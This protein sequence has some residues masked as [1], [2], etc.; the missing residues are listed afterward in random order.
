V[1]WLQSEIPGEVRVPPWLLAEVHQ[2]RR[3][4]F[5]ELV[6]AGRSIAQIARTLNLSQRRVKEMK[7][8]LAAVRS[9]A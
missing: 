1:L 6:Q 4:T 9:A 5:A 3:A 7:R 2:E 8:A